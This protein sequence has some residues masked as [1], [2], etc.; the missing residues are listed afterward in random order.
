MS[1][2][3]ELVK[4]RVEDE[5]SD[6]G[7]G[8]GGGPD[9]Q[10]VQDCLDAVG[11]G[12]G[13][14]F[15]EVFRGKRLYNHSTQEW[16][17]WTGHSW[18]LDV[19]EKHTKTSCEDIAVL[20][21]EEKA[22]IDNEISKLEDSPKKKKS[23]EARSK[24]IAGRAKRLRSLAGR[25]ECMEMATTNKNPIDVF[26]HQM[27]NRP[28]LVAVKNGVVDLETGAL[29]DGK[30]EDFLLR[31]SPVKY[32]P[33]ASY[34][35]WDNMLFEIYEDDDKIAFLQRLFGAA[36]F[37]WSR[38][39]IITVFFGQ[40]RNGKDTIFE[41]ISH[42]LGNLAGV[43]QPEMLLDQG[44]VKNSS[45]PSPDIMALKG[46]R[47][48][49]GSET[50][51]GA[52]LDVG[53]V[54]LLTGGG[55]LVGR[56]P[57]DKHATEFDPTHTLF[58]LTN[59]KPSAGN[60]YAFWKRAYLISH[61]FSFVSD[62]KGPDEK[63]ADK[64]LKDKLRAGSSGILLWMVE[65]AISY[66]EGGLRPPACVLEDTAEYQRNEDMIG[67]FVE[68]RCV[69]SR[70]LEPKFP[71]IPKDLVLNFSIEEMKT[72]FKDIRE[73]FEAWYCEVLGNKVPSPKW[74]GKQLKTRFPDK[75]SGNIYYMGIGINPSPKKDESKQPPYTLE[76]DTL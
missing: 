31:S 21:L 57:H 74:I 3:L 42:V 6:G 43:I 70:D 10:F 33:N 30:P 48:A 13:V 45:G 61:P 40:G 14:L 37:G 35:F 19:G 41:A 54:K 44:R 71:G 52:R 56:W 36:L 26:G 60:D 7:N 8:D 39:H 9:P 17:H 51:E 55:R 62:P 58:L 66:L 16:Y 67:D 38:E 63:L 1:K 23:L 15:A 11:Y 59:N 28:T 69:I 29:R 5:G 34:E 49:V 47:L 75:K 18:A 25:K 64:H 22:S 50:N 65:G 20:Y 76:E 73:V 46:L 12:D 27:D 53:R 2:V 68:A 32:D 24:F 72:S 4:Q